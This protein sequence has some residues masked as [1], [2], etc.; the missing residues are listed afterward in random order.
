MTLRIRNKS[1]LSILLHMQARGIVSGKPKNLKKVHYY[2]MCMH[3][4]NYVVSTSTGV[5]CDLS[6][7]FPTVNFKRLRPY[8][9]YTGNGPQEDLCLRSVRVGHNG[10]ILY[11]LH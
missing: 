9:S 2:I 7:Y 11:T 1:L 4:N 8:H 3:A 5:S 6:S 10:M